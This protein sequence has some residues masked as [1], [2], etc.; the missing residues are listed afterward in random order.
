MKVTYEEAM[1]SFTKLSL[2]GQKNA[3]VLLWFIEQHKPPTFDDVVKAWEDVYDNQPGLEFDTNQSLR[4]EVHF[5]VGPT[6]RLTKRLAV[7]D[8]RSDYIEQVNTS[9]K[10]HQ[11]I[12]LT[13]RYLE[14][15]KHHDL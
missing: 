2:D 12:N 1:K 7:V 10:Y 4:L 9:I 14:A 11:A 13:I 15:Q 8:L 3:D 5:R 6:H